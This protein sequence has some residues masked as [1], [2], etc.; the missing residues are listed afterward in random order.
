MPFYLVTSPRGRWVTCENC[1]NRYY[2]T[3]RSCFMCED[4]DYFD[5]L[6]D[7]IQNEIDRL[8]KLK[9]KIENIIS[10]AKKKD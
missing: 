2:K 6:P 9:V 10:K 1:I 7:V 5:P 4:N 8:I 3:E